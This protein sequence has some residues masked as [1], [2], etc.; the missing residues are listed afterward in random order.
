MNAEEKSLRLFAEYVRVRASAFLEKRTEHMKKVSAKRM[1][2][3][4]QLTSELDTLYT[5]KL[6]VNLIP[7]DPDATDATDM[8]KRFDT[9]HLIVYHKKLFITAYPVSELVTAAGEAQ[10]SN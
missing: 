10:N 4:V 9:D 8:C 5:Q 6:A 3:L 2:M 7:I 1:H